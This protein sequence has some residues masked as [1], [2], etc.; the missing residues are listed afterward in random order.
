MRRSARRLGERSPIRSTSCTA[1]LPAAN[2]SC[3]RGARGRSS[4]SIMG[5]IPSSPRPR[6]TAG[7]ATTGLGIAP[8]Q[9]D[10]VIGIAK[11]YTTRVGNGSFP[12]EFPE[13]FAETFRKRAG[14]FGATTGRPR[15]CGWFDAVLLRQ[16]VRLNGLD[17]I[18]LTKLDVL[19]GIKQLRIAVGYRLG[20]KKL[21][22]PPVDPRDWAACRP[23]YEEEPGWSQK[24]SGVRTWGGLPAAVREYVRRIESLAGRPVR[25]MSVGAA[26]QAVLPVPAGVRRSRVAKI[27]RAR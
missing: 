4:T 19:S 23:I 17:E 6:T 12:T 20:R 24:I 25:L 13:K 11:G 8:N 14:E 1:P 21:L 26:R 22:H 27:S 10:K 2:R 3:A 5:A 16:A 18:Y 9:I 15:R 7:G